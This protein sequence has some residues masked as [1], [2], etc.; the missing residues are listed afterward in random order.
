LKIIK[1]QIVTN[2][3]LARYPE[4]IPQAVNALFGLSA[5]PVDATLG[6]GEVRGKFKSGIRAQFSLIL[7]KIVI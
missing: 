2:L 7:E 5:Q 6:S 4:F 3:L 1:E